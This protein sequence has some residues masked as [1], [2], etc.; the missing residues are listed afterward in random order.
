MLRCGVSESSAGVGDCQ[1][2]GCWLPSLL[3]LDREEGNGS[4]YLMSPS[5]SY[6]SRIL[7]SDSSSRL[8]F[9]FL[10]KEQVSLKLG[11]E[12]EHEGKICF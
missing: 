10:L 5:F 11:R 12:R 6:S 8:V 3:A 2:Q 9:F 7:F 4:S 1:D